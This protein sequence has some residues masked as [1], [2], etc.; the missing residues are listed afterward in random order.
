MAT[1]TSAKKCVTCEYFVGA[2]KELAKGYASAVS[3]EANAYGSCQ[4]S[5]K[6]ERK[7]VNGICNKY[8]K[9]RMLK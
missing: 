9:W 4:V 3:H 2:G 1:V 6:N 7:Q 5:G 8:V